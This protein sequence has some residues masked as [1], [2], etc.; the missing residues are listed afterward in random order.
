MPS[1]VDVFDKS[2]FWP[3]GSRLRRI[4]AKV[5]DE[6]E[7]GTDC[8]V[9]LKLK[10]RGTTETCTT[11]D[12]DG[13][14]NSWARGDTEVY[15][16]PSV[17]NYCRNFQPSESLQFKFTLHPLGCVDHMQLSWVRVYFGSGSVSYFQ[18]SLSTGHW[19]NPTSQWM[20]F[21]FKAEWQPWT[22][23]YMFW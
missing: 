2:F 7:S 14:G 20:D 19:W 8:I 3:G 11:G 13:R 15:D 5:V 9:R 23:F 21:D 12:L 6:Y 16:G 10:N 18:W 17:Y 4:E 22:V 1:Y